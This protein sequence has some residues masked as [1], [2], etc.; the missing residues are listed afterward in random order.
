MEGKCHSEETKRK[1][2]KTHKG[3]KFS[4]ET[5]QKLSKSHKG[6]RLSDAAKRKISKASKKTWARWRQ[7]RAENR[8]TQND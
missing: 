2:S 1:M 8:G 6:K 7:E 3:K 4:K 5:K